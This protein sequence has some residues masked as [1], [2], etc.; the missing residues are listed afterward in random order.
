MKI[1]RALN[2]IV[3]VTAGFWH[4]GEMKSTREKKERK[5]N[6]NKKVVSWVGFLV[7]NIHMGKREEKRPMRRN[8]AYNATA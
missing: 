4:D 5:E 2:S 6:N 7:S 3:L 8:L 1:S